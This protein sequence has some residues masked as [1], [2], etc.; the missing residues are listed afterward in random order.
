MGRERGME[1]K[2]KTHESKGH[3]TSDIRDTND[4]NY[5]D[6]YGEVVIMER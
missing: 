5:G 3:N 6:L 4:H 2:S 1:H